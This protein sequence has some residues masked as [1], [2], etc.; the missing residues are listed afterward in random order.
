[1]DSIVSIL[2]YVQIVLSLL[3]I[4]GVILQQTGAGLGGAFGDN[5][6]SAFHTR[7][8]SE[9]TIFRA[10]LILAIL[11]ALVSILDVILAG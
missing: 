5:F 10:T 1:M 11:F 3:L 4:V 9:K 8:G 7:R 6:S 2:P